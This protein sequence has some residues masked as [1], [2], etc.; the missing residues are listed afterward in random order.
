MPW[1]YAGP[2]AKPV[3]P[4]TLEELH[5]R[6]ANGTILPD[7]YVIE[8]TGQPNEPRAWK[9][10]QELFLSNPGLPPLPPASTPPPAPPVPPPQPSAPAAHPHLFPSQAVKPPVFSSPAGP[11][12]YYTVRK[13]NAWCLWGFWLGLLSLPF[14]FVCGL[15]MPMAFL[16]LVCSMGGL[17]QLS[18]RREE[19]G[20][21]MA[22]AGLLLAA[23]ALVIAVT[24][25]VWVVPK[26][27]KEHEQT[28]TEQSTS[29]SE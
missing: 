14:L 2:D 1:Y 28:V 24:L 6:R 16:A 8:H 21:G 26:V 19:A 15:G 22:V 20:R 7:T 23:L 5:A 13:T 25:L 18:H 11:D 12:P 9:H 17:V 3:G 27:I 4:V 29:D 10:Y